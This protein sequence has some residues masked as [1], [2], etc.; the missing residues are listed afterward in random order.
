MRDSRSSGSTCSSTHTFNKPRID[1]FTFCNANVGCLQRTQLSFFCNFEAWSLLYLPV[2]VLILTCTSSLTNSCCRCF[3]MLVL[4]M[5]STGCQSLSLRN[6]NRAPQI[7]PITE[8]VSNKYHVSEGTLK[9]K[10]NDC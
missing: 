4:M 6:I 2:S 9:S 8:A 1:L 5:L 7:A 10:K 3:F